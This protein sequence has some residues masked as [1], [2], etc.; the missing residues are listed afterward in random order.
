M[1]QYQKLAET[2]QGGETGFSLAVVPEWTFRFRLGRRKRCQRVG[3]VFS[4]LVRRLSQ[5]LAAHF[6]GIDA[7]WSSWFGADSR[8]A[9]TSPSEKEGDDIRVA[10]QQLGNCTTSMT[11]GSTRFV[12][13]RWSDRIQIANF[14]SDCETGVQRPAAW[15]WW[16]SKLAPANERRVLCSL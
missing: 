15:R 2:R 9:L 5:P 14:A 12:V 6:G 11:G 10:I 1:H 3:E 13:R 7:S 8:M 4:G 16:L